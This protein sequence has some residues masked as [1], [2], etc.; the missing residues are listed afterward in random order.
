M[1]VS[2][3]PPPGPDRWGRYGALAALG[4]PEWILPVLA[5]ANRLCHSRR[6][7]DLSTN[8]GAWLRREVRQ[9]MLVYASADQFFTLQH[10]GQPDVTPRPIA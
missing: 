10:Y 7:R 9:M 1:T 3:N 4:L 2:S 5:Q 8:P 6:P